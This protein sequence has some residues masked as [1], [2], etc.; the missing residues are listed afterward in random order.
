MVMNKNDLIDAVSE[1]TGLARSDATRA[2]ESVLAAITEALR[3]GDAVALSGFGT[4]LAKT[5]AARTGRN[6]RTGEAIAIPASR[7]PAFKA[8][9]ALKDALN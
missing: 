3:A 2:V 1:R 7:A 9:K 6:P 4:F 8:G 5:R